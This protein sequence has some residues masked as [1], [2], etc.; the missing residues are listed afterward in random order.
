M[1]AQ[2][3][4]SLSKPSEPKKGKPWL[5]NTGR[6]HFKTGTCTN[7]GGRPKGFAAM[8]RDKTHSGLELV[9]IALKVMRGKLMVERISYDQDGNERVTK[10]SP[11]IKDR[12]QAL[13]W[14]ADRGW[15]KSMETI[16]LANPDGTNLISPDMLAAAALLAKGLPEASATVEAEIVP[17]TKQDAS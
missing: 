13:Q 16:A 9:E 3:E 10:E 7:P 8:V 15:G 1:V 2:S 12:L 11:A 5:V 17:Q 4:K 14:L 6:T